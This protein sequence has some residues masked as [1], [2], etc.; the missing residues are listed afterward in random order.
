MRKRAPLV[1]LGPQSDIIV[2]LNKPKIMRNDG[3]LRKLEYVPTKPEYVKYLQNTDARTSHLF[4]PF[5]LCY[6]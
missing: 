4:G 6:V 2:D 3:E 5:K 1:S